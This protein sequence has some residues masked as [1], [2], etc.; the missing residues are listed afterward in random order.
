MQ[1]KQRPLKSK[2]KLQLKWYPILQMP[3]VQ[4]ISYPNVHRVGCCEVVID[5]KKCLNALSLLLSLPLLRW[6][7]DIVREPSL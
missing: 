5:A 3:L 1:L 2:A 4:L 7:L 6:C